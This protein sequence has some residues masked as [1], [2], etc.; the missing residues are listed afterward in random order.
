MLI[1]VVGMDIETETPWGWTPLHIAASHNNLEAAKA[2]VKRGANSRAK[3]N[4]SAPARWSNKTPFQLSQIAGSA[5]VG[6]FLKTYIKSQLA[7][8]PSTRRR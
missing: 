7:A 8:K 5:K 2:L 4:A 1:D 3:S 6:R